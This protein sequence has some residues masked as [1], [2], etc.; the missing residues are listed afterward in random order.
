MKRFAVYTACIG[1]YD[2]ICHSK[3]ISDQFDYYLFTDQ[4]RDDKD[5]VWNVVAAPEK[6]GLSPI[7]LARYIKTHPHELLPKYDAWLWVDLNLVFV[8]TFFYDRFHEWYDGVNLLA[9]NPHP[10]TD[11]VYEH[12]YEM[13]C[14]GFENDITCL[15]VMRFL[16][17]QD[18]PS[19]NGLNE[20]GVL[21]RKNKPEMVSFDEQWWDCITTLSKRDQFTFNYLLCKN[22]FRCEYILPQDEPASVSSH[23]KYGS[24]TSQ[25]KRKMVQMDYEE[26][27]RQKVRKRYPEIYPPFVEQYKRMSTHANYQLRLKVWGWYRYYPP[28]LYN[29][30]KRK[31]NKLFSNE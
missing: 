14:F 19:H 24:H 30:I 2:E 28:K 20:T 21:F 16:Q 25:V 8:D 1:G 26:R 7:L 23:L 29:V 9:A 3:V 18:Y 13:C 5:G 17:E 27:I 11:D 6:N 22:R 31:I 10:A 4:K 15:K 12:I